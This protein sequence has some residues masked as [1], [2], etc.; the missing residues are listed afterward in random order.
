[1]ISLALVLKKVKLC[2]NDSGPSSAICTFCCGLLGDDTVSLHH[3]HLSI[4]RTLNPWW[5]FGRSLTRS[6][7]TN[8]DRH[9]AHS[10]SRSGSFSSAV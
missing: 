6:P 9:M 5:H 1:M 3:R 10:V 4:H 7:D 8:S 2:I